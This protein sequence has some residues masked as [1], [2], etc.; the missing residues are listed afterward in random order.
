MSHAVDDLEGQRGD[1]DRDP[2]QAMK[3]HSVPHLPAFEMM[4][5]IVSDLIPAKI[6]VA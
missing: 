5:R 2:D 3:H 1:E 4:S 6:D